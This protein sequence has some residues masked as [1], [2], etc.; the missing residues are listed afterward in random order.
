M[1]Q[2]ETNNPK[3][4]WKMLESLGPKRRAS[5]PMKVYINED[6]DT[7]CNLTAILDKW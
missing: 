4:F 5:I 6:N 3:K 1:K 2:V 7:T